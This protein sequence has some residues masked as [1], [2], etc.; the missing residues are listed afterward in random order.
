MTIR[1]H[2]YSPIKQLA[3]FLQNVLVRELSG[4][5]MHSPMILHVWYHFVQG[6]LRNHIS[7]V[8][9][10]DWDSLL[11]SA[12]FQMTAAKCKIS[13]ICEIWVWFKESNSYFCKIE[14]CAYGEINEWV[15][16]TPTPALNHE[17]TQLGPLLLTWI[18]F[19]P[20]MDK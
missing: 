11:I 8:T 13:N 1:V 17:Q 19:Y 2:E 18:N 4:V 5:P 15:I 12:I 10:K 3:N 7:D 9:K 14:H 6:T 16:V 20:S